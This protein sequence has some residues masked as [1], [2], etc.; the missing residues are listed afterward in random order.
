V[1]FELY[2]FYDRVLIAGMTAIVK[3]I[4]AHPEVAV[5]AVIEP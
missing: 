3:I 2:N 1:V 4:K 5:V